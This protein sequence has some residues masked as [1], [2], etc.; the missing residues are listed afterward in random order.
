[1]TLFERYGRQHCFPLWKKYALLGIVVLLNLHLI[2]SDLLTFLHLLLVKFHSFTVFTT[3][4]DIDL[5][6]FTL[7]H[8]VTVE[9]IETC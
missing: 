6:I 8:F 7:H 2:C 3:C 1:M 9:Y 4:V 5:Y